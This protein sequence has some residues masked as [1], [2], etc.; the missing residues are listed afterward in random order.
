MDSKEGITVK[1]ETVWQR[2]IKTVEVLPEEFGAIRIAIMP[3]GESGITLSQVEAL[4]L[5]RMI[6]EQVKDI[7][8][9]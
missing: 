6:E 3:V 8:R 1:L 7:R 4:S 5:A 9:K 2:Q